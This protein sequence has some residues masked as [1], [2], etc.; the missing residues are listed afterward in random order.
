MKTI[1][2]V[3]ERQE[4]KS[5]IGFSDIVRIINDPK[6][7]EYF[8][9]VEFERHDTDYGDEYYSECG[10]AYDLTI[11]GKHYNFGYNRVVEDREN[12]AQAESH[13]SKWIKCEGKYTNY[14]AIAY[15]LINYK[16]LKRERF[17]KN[18]I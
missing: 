14:D 15:D 9:D 7:K 11:L 5:Y 10:T 4:K 1:D 8:P 12:W 18:L 16:K 13:E 6:F 17:L 2:Y 3:K